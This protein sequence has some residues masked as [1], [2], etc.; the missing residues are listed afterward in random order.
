MV[1]DEFCDDVCPSGALW[2]HQCCT[3]WWENVEHRKGQL[4][5]VD[6]VTADLIVTGDVYLVRPCYLRTIA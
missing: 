5:C 3:M 6:G 4:L 2:A 1:C